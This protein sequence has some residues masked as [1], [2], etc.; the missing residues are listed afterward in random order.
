MQRSLYPDSIEVDNTQLE[1]TESTKISEILG[2]TLA[3]AQM[4]VVTGLSVT[5]NT[6]DPT[7]VDVAVGTAY[8]PNA[9]LLTLT[10]ARLSLPL[11]DSTS[12]VI[13]YVLL[14]YTETQTTPEPSEDGLSIDETLVAT[15]GTIQIVTEATYNALVPSVKALSALIAIVPATGG[16]IDGLNIVTPEPFVA[17]L[18]P[19]QPVLIT[20]VAISGIDFS[21]PVGVG[22]LDFDAP[23]ANGINPL[24]PAPRI[25]W[26]AP[27]DTYGTYVNIPS[28]G[29]YVLLSAS[30]HSLTITVI[31]VNLPLIDQTENITVDSLYAVPT[32]SFTAADYLHRTY[33]GSG[34]PSPKNPHALTFADLGGSPNGQVI[35]HQLLF[36][37]NGIR[38]GSNSIF[39]S[40]AVIPVAGSSPDYIAITGPITGDTYDV[41]GTVLNTIT[42]TLINWLTSVSASISLYEMLIDSAGNPLRSLRLEHPLTPTVTGVAIIDLDDSIGAGAYNLVYNRNNKTLQWDSGDPVLIRGDGNTTL[43]SLT[44]KKIVVNVGVVT[45]LGFGILPSTGGPVFTD[46][47]TVYA[48]ADRKLNFLIGSVPWDGSHNLGWTQELV[49]PR[50][51]TDKRLFGML[52]LPELRDD[53]LSQD[54]VNETY[55]YTVG[56]GV[57]TFGDFNGPTGIQVAITLLAGLPGS[58]FVKTG[59]YDPFTISSDDVTIRTAGGVIIDGVSDVLTPGACITVAANRANFSGFQLNNAEIG[60]FQVSGND[61]VGSNLIF[62]STLT[63]M[64]AYTAGL[65]C[66]YTGN[67]RYVRTLTGAG[68]VTPID[69]IVLL[70]ATAGAFIVTWPLAASCSHGIKSKKIDPTTNAITIDPSGSDTLDYDTALVLD[71]YLD[72]EL[73][74]PISG[75]W[76]T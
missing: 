56:D 8:A 59:T 28:N 9:E 39:L 66:T 54:S 51:P 33:L 71:V 17:V 26:Q 13:N 32:P 16:P 11:A 30:G 58:I 69:D 6:I 36:H 46:S 48:I 62:G 74:D 1:Y 76:I 61:S 73:L 10:S 18:A 20:G 35:E 57:A 7:K 12:G 70:D 14:T 23:P 60:V 24:V 37:S 47:V 29:S 50:Q 52:G 68:S 42:N 3:M 38:R 72:S 21:T 25:R 44:G 67:K 55:T 63:E 41:N 65:R 34:T 2:R 53:V 64:L 4:G 27:G 31:A 43:Y 5:V 75:G 49:N 15:S 22:S 40:T 19:S 45:E